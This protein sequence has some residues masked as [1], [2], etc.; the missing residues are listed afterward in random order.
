MS[1]WLPK[2]EYDRIFAIVPRLTVEVV[3]ADGRGVLLAERDIEPNVGAWHLPGGTVYWGERVLDA[4]VRKA[5]EELGI[6][7]AVGELL[8]YV[9]YPSHY[10]NSLDSPVGLAFRARPC[11]PLS[12]EPRL[13]THCRFFATPPPGLYAEQLA[14][15]TDAGCWPAAV[16]R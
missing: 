11:E 7:V 9:E 3:I 15:L 6:A 10:E 16:D 1:P 12:D 4:V 5:R 13:L 2:E 8:G 14:F